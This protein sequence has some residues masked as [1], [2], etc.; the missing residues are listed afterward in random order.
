ML[1]NILILKNGGSEHVHVHLPPPTL[2]GFRPRARPQKSFA[3]KRNGVSNLFMIFEPLKG[4][5]HV[6]VT[7][8][9]T[10]ADWAKCMK[11]I[12]DELYPEAEKITIVMDNLNTHTPAS[13]Y[14]WI[15]AE[16]AK[17]IAD[18]IDR[19]HRIL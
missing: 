6:E 1:K 12:V 8:R 9:R 13:L 3:Y 2:K 10:K 5:R 17:R 4:K 15:T 11:Q 16:E 7:D 18:K 14:E 19:I